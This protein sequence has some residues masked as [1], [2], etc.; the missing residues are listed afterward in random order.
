M[1]GD[2]P[3]LRIL[4]QVLFTRHDITLTVYWS[5]LQYQDYNH[6]FTPVIGF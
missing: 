4:D 1:N 2:N 5:K 3:V 6:A